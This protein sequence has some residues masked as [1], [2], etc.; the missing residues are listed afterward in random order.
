MKDQ[1]DRG[2]ALPGHTGAVTISQGH[3]AEKPRD[4]QGRPVPPEEQGRRP[5]EGLG[6]RT[7]LQSQACGTPS[8][9]CREG[10]K[11]SRGKPL[12]SKCFCLES[13]S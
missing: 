10:R 13:L 7:H 4:E 5:R 12:Q 1:V 2:R 3:A 11:D 9:A 6:A 8:S